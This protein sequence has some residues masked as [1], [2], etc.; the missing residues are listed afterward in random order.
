MNPKWLNVI[1]LFLDIAGA[2]FLT[3][4]LIISKKKA[5]ELGITRFCG[6]TDEENLK[7]P[8]VVDRLRQS[9]NAI[10][11]LVLLIVGFLLQII[12]NWPR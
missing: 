12:G 3:W 4:G 6:D 9:R 5:I 1:G 2:C 7:L 8:V 11:G 10:I